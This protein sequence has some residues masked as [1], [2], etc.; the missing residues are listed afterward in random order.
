MSFFITGYYLG[1]S[2]LN[3]IRIN[4]YYLTIYNIWNKL[5]NN[6]WTA[7]QYALFTVLYFYKLVFK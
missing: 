1:N 2:K 5:T 4:I 7:W 6:I 3:L